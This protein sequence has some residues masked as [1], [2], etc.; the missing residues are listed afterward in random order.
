MGKIY[1]SQLFVNIIPMEG[2]SYIFK[3]PPSILGSGRLPVPTPQ[4]NFP[5]FCVHV[6]L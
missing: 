1:N 6:A 3:N 2:S 5:G 4:T